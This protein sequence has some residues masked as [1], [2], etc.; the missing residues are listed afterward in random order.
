MATKKMKVKFLNNNLI[1]IQ[2]LFPNNY[3]VNCNNNNSSDLATGPSTCAF[4]LF[5]FLVW[6]V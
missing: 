6:M 3:F 1:I 2:T 5:F 4:N